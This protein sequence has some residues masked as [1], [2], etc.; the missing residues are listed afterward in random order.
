MAN[1][2]Q[3]RVL[4][5]DEN[6]L[7]RFGIVSVVNLHPLLRVCKEAADARSARASHSTECP[8]IVVL[9]IVL[10]H[11][12]GIELLREF[13]SFKPRCRSVVVSAWCDPAIDYAISQ[14][15]L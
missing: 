9:D 11:G 4:V 7:T 12:D 8:Q 15:W 3:L 5:V 1:E 13:A 14:D 2:Q 6:P 10:P